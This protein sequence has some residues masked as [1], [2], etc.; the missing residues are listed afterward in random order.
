[1][2]QYGFYDEWMNYKLTTTDLDFHHL[3][4]G[5]A[6]KLGRIIYKSTVLETSVA[7]LGI[8]LRMLKSRDASK[9][10]RLYNAN[11]GA[12]G[13][14]NFAKTGLGNI[15]KRDRRDIEILLD[16]CLELFEYRNGLA[17][18]IPTQTPDGIPI[19]WRQVEPAKRVAGVP[20]VAIQIDAQNLEKIEKDFDAALKQIVLR[21][22]FYWPPCKGENPRPT[23][24]E[25]YQLSAR[26]T[27]DVLYP[28]QLI[29]RFPQ[30]EN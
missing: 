16:A 22:H 1:M 8:H 9:F 7:M 20:G 6:A 5:V 18:G 13:S 26:T 10:D 29:A 14:V 19:M 2:V 11:I 28:E 24:K 3:T 25:N 15:P 4:D 21:L 17:H 30:G 12:Q 27:D 23:E